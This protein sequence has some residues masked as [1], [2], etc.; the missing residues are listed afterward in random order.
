[1]GLP[2]LPLE[3]LS[4]VASFLPP[5]QQAVFALVSRRFTVAWR[6]GLLG[7]EADRQAVK[8]PK[9][10]ERGT[11]SSHQNE[12]SVYQKERWMLLLFLEKDIADKW[13]LCDDCF[14]LHPVQAL[15][16]AEKE[17]PPIQPG[18]KKKYYDNL[19]NNPTASKPRTCR[20]LV[21]KTPGQPNGSHSPIGIVDLC[22]CTKLTPAKRSRL[23]VP[24][25]LLDNHYDIKDI[26]HRHECNNKYGDT[27][28][29]ISHFPF[30]LEDEKRSLN[31][32]IHYKYSIPVG[33]TSPCPW[34]TCPHLSLYQ[35]ISTMTDCLITHGP[36]TNCNTCKPVCCCPHCKTTI[37]HFRREHNLL[38]NTYLITLERRFDDENWG[39]N[40]VYPF[41]RQRRYEMAEMARL[42]EESAPRW[43]RWLA[44]SKRIM[45]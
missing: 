1:M 34:M 11:I 22:P 12:L 32:H 38:E 16:L 30:F 33:S 45:S 17:L 21:P 42:K 41:A 25:M 10:V 29:V 13:L 23:I 40:I 24:D 36:G 31:Y 7:D 14:I 27:A 37:V 15:Q 5:G 20:S 4:L 35:M 2:D 18:Q 8:L 19:M 44:K 28:L 26:E 43:R 6:G 3:V 39:K 9:E